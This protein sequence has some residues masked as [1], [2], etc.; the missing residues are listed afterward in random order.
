M[1]YGRIAWGVLG[2][3]TLL[4]G[5]AGVGEAAHPLVTEDTGTLGQ[6]RGQVE[7][8][9]EWSRDR[10]AGSRTDSTQLATTITVGI[11]ETVDVS[12]GVPYQ[13]DRTTTDGV[14]DTSDG[15]G[16]LTVSGKWRYWETGPWSLAVK[17]SL[18]VPT[19]DAQAGLGAGRVG[20]AL[21][22]AGSWAAAPW[23]VHANVGYLRDANTRGEREQ[24]WHASLAGEWQARPALRLVANVGAEAPRTGGSTTPLAFVL[25]GLIYAVSDTCDLDLGVRGGLTR[26]EVDLAFLAGAAWRW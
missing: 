24:R 5:A 23:A 26:P 13:H 12:V 8:T 21:L 11:W 9:G 7:L 17:P 15:V 25:G 1:G 16:D 20:G 22:L 10:A 4:G 19:G 6:W 3:L 14:R 2:M 18:S